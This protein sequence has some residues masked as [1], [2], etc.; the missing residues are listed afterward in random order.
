MTGKHAGRRRRSISA[1]KN[2]HDDIEDTLTGIVEFVNGDVKG[3]K[4]A[5]TGKKSRLGL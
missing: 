3:K 4:K 2:D 5:R 1:G